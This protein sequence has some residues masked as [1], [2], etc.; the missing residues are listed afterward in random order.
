MF[1]VL[2]LLKRETS[3]L[4]GALAPCSL[5][6]SSNCLTFLSVLTVSSVRMVWHASR[7]VWS[8]QPSQPNFSDGSLIYR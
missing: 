3:A 1:Y 6:S 4:L 2:H 8:W 5:S 7:F